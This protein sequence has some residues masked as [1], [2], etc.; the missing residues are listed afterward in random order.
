[1]RKHTAY[2]A[3][4]SVV[5][6]PPFWAAIQKD[7][8]LKVGATFVCTW[9]LLLAFVVVTPGECQ[10]KPPATPL[11][12]NAASIAQLEQVPGIG[13]ATAKAIAQFREKSGP[14]RRVEDLLAIRGISQRKLAALRPYVTVVSSTTA[15]APH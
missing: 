13:P 11:D 7:A 3:V 10:K 12:L 6:A 1:V 5:V 2:K 9:L 14:F 8:H 4:G 15:K